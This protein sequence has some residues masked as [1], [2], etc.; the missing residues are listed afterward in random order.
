MTVVDTA[1]L[2]EAIRVESRR[3]VADTV[4]TLETL[5]ALTGRGLSDLVAMTESLSTRSGLGRAETLTLL[6]NLARGA[7]VSLADSLVASEALARRAGWSVSESAILTE[8][9][10]T[11]S[12]RQIG[13][14]LVLQETLEAVLS[15]LSA[16]LADALVA[17]EALIRRMQKTL[18]VTLGLTEMLGWAVNVFDQPGRIKDP[19]GDGRFLTSDELAHMWQYWPRP[20]FCLIP[21]ERVSVGRDQ[22]KEEASV[23][24]VCDFVRNPAM[25]GTGRL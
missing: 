3:G 22:I 7:S 23:R 12:G 21:R 17:S 20:M 9:L 18:A 5:S 6:E 1:S 11:A 13:E 15:G 25:W 16:A 24:A 4:G 19:L 8:A 14:S 10:R 2:A